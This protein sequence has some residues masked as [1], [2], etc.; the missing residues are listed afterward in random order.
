[1]IAK[2]MP[3]YE[4]VYTK[5]GV[6]CTGETIQMGFDI[7]AGYI[8]RGGTNGILNCPVA[9]GQSKLISADAMWINTQGER[10][11]NEGGQTHDIYYQVAH[12]DD[13]KFY[14]V[15]DQAMVDALKDT[16]KEQY[17]AGIEKGLFAKADTV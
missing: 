3:G 2:C 8:G 12:F 14:A 10:F 15:Y 13:R 7:G 4:G 16:L 9:A 17:D 6:G 5:V 1:M 11:A